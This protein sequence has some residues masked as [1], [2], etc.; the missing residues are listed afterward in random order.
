MSLR[1]IGYRLVQIDIRSLHLTQVTQHEFSS[2]SPTQH[3]PRR[4]LSAFK[5]L[6][7][8]IIIAWASSLTSQT[9]FQTFNY[10]GEALQMYADTTEASQ[11]FMLESRDARIKRM[12]SLMSEN[13]R[14]RSL[15]HFHRPIYSASFTPKQTNRLRSAPQRVFVR[16]VQIL[17]IISAAFIARTSHSFTIASLQANVNRTHQVNIVR[18]AN[19]FLPVKIPTNYEPT[20][21]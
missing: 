12:E 20:K 11:R 14:I 17:P 21:L 18:P 4:R 7:V 5:V 9:F 6:W 2:F 1:P 8:L 19:L 15:T 16:R 3:K 10:P 13:Y